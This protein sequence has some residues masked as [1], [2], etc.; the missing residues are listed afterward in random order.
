MPLITAD[1]HVCVCALP[2]RMLC[3]VLFLPCIF[4]MGDDDEAR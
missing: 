1:E 3:H 2:S 4:G